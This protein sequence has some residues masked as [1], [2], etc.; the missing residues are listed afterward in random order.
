MFDVPWLSLSGGVPSAP[1][2]GVA[3]SCPRSAQEELSSI[4]A[5][6]KDWFLTRRLAMERHLSLNRLF[7]RHGFVGLG[8]NKSTNTAASAA[9]AVLWSDLVRG[10]PQLD[11]VL[12]LDA[13]TVKADQYFKVFSNATDLDNPCRAP[14]VAHLRCL[15][16]NLQQNQQQNRQTCNR[17]FIHFDACRQMLKT[18]QENALLN[19]MK[20][21]HLKDAHAKE[22][23]TRRNQLLDQIN[24]C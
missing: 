7:Q 8:L 3:T 19:S 21:Q 1:P 5:E 2:C 17:T 12:S 15:K 18:Q 23:F 22:I 20:R 14:G 4:E 16:D 24:S 6:L 9:T 10:R 11:D 13:K